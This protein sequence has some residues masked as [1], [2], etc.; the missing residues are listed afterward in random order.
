VY[1]KFFSS[2]FRVPAELKGRKIVKVRE[3][4]DSR[5]M[6]YTAYNKQGTYEFTKNKAA[7]TGST[8]VEN[9]SSTYVRYI[10]F[11]SF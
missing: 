7:S 1:I 5:R 4:E 10:H 3:K 8:W 6:S 11:I 2:E 9:K